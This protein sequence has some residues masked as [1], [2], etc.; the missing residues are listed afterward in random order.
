MAAPILSRVPS[1]GG[2][3]LDHTPGVDFERV[4]RRHLMT[5]RAWFVF[6]IMFK[7]GGSS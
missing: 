1:L 7:R 3:A 5:N 4:M 6:I 2:A